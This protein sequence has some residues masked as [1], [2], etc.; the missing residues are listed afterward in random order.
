MRMNFFVEAGSMFAGPTHSISTKAF[1]NITAGARFSL[2]SQRLPQLQLGLQGTRL[3]RN[4][5]GNFV[6]TRSKKLSCWACNKRVTTIML[7][8]GPSMS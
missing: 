2:I 4:V 5:V 3:S 8:Q 1:S 6:R 7:A